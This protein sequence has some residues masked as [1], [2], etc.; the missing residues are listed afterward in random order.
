MTEEFATFKKFPTIDAARELV[1]L[2]DQ[3][4]VP[5]EVD[6]NSEGT[7]TVFLGD[8]PADKVEVKI[9]RQDFDYVHSLLRSEAEE[10]AG[11]VATDHYLYDFTDEELKDVI[12]KQDE[13]SELDVLIAQ[14][15]LS[16]RG[17][18]ISS[19]TIEEHKAKRLQELKAKEPSPS[20]WLFIGYFISA[21]S[22]FIVLALLAR[23][24]GL[25]GNLISFALLITGPMIGYLIA[26]SKKTL[27]NGEKTFIYD[28]K[29]RRQGWIITLIGTA[30][31][32]VCVILVI[33]FRIEIYRGMLW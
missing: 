25:F 21:F 5:F 22:T 27:P 31:F 7:S 18:E 30:S 2:L 26:S 10:V 3:Y 13:W 19:N 1:A 17:I 15:I 33:I 16:Q 6:D 23:L 24:P 9:R 29:T 28:A 11:Q 4:A 8:Q 20:K 32:L 12:F 14:K